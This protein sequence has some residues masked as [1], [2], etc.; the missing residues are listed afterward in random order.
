VAWISIDAINWGLELVGA[1]RAVYV[2]VGCMHV[3][4]WV[5]MVISIMIMN[6][7]LRGEVGGLFGSS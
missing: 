6:S 4:A 7:V 5:S 3:H 1:A 2:S